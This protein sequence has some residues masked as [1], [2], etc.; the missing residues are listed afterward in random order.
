MDCTKSTLGFRKQ[1][2]N[3]TGFKT[4]YYPSGKDGTKV[5]KSPPN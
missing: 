5:D 2:V 1:C 4:V 3:N